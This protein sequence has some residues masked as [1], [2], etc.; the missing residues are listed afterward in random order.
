LGFESVGFVADEE[1]DGEGLEVRVEF[2]AF[3]VV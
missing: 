3:F 2:D 1:V